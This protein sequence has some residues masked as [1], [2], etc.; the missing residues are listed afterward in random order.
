MA[1]KIKPPEV[2]YN[3][4]RQNYLLRW[5]TPSGE[6][7]TETFATKEKADQAKAIKVTLG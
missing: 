6:S 1:K 2:I 4:K 7:S 5:Y 3:S